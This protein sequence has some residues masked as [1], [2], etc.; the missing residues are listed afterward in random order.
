M[1]MGIDHPLVKDASLKLR[2]YQEALIANAIS[3]ST[4]VVLP[5]GLGKTVIAA[6]VAA[7]RL[8]EYPEGKVLFLA[9]TKPLVVQHERSFAKL[10]DIDDTCILTGT[11]APEKRRQMLDDS[12]IIFATPQTIENDIMRGTPLDDVCLIIFDEAH[13][14]QGNYSYVTIA[15]QYLKRGKHQLTLGL[16]ASPSSERDKV[17]DIC[18]SLGLVNVEARSEQDSDV[19]GYVQDVRVDWVRV[20][21]PPRFK[22]IHA[23]LRQALKKSVERLYGMGALK[24]KDVKK[25]TKGALLRVQAQIR[26]DISSGGGAFMAAS[27]VALAIKANHA[28][29]LLET[30]GIV[31]LDQYIKRLK[32]QKS[33]AVTRLLADHSMM[34]AGVEVE[35][36][37]G[38]GV[39][40]PKVAKLVSIVKRYKGKK[41]LVFTQYR[42]SVDTIIDKL[43]EADITAREFI[44]QAKRGTKK[45]MTQKEQIRA[46]ERFRE[47]AYDALVATSVAEEGLD[48]PKV[49]AVIFYEPVPSEIR[50][51]QRRGRTG[52]TAAGAVYVLLAKGTRDEGYYWSAYHKEKKM[53]RLVD[54]MRENGADL[55]PPDDGQA[56]LESFTED[57]GDR[58]T[59]IV[60]GRERNSRLL[61]ILK[62]G[63]QLEIKNLPVGDFIVSDRTAIERKTVSDLLSSLI[64]GRLMPQLAQ[65]RANYEVPVLI[66]EGGES[67]YSRGIHPNAVR[68]AL[69]SAVLDIGIRVL[70][71]EDESDTAGMILAMAKREQLDLKRPVSIRAGKKPE[72]LGDRQRYVVG[73][74]PNVS[75][76]LAD[77]LLKSL[78]SVKAVMDAGEK[79]LLGIEGI[80]KKKASDIIEVSRGEYED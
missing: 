10:L 29:E 45:G 68:G 79:E 74:L 9:P 63:S 32:K 28:L 65:L 73:S 52:R 59:V 51:I 31:A 41:V 70:P 4:L 14:A 22:A 64:D 72:L 62:E 37:R 24:S 71:A 18:K 75:A 12:R 38:E 43:N 2:R 76:V 39:E 21:L 34:R 3:Q 6:M 69:A 33:K 78:G 36:M 57:D 30:Q 42:D 5:T 1:L 47:G 55:A 17:E 77:R 54:E 61:T 58:V 11:I 50:T 66:I 27:E 80:G 46:L 49:D 67:L 8:F 60:D 13:R 48:I 26:A 23:D 56:S 15:G 40:H 44:G 20:E 16:T 25:V 7:H 35:A 19:R 53:G